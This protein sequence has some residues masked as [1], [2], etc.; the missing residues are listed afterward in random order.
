MA[1]TVAQIAD[2]AFDA[3][4][5]EITDAI[6]TATVTRTALGARNVASD[7]YAET[8]TTDTG[9]GVI[10]TERPADIFPDLA[11]GPHD[12]LILLEGLSTVPKDGDKLT[13]AHLTAAPIVAVQNILG[14]DSLFY[15]IAR[16][17]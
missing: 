10:V 11:I 16:G 12:Q 15:V 7:S 14:A 4:A 17:L 2:E 9:R 3:V 1:Q 13:F 8:E 5:A 6:Q